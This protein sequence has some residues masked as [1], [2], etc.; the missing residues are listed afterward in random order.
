MKLD[1]RSKGKENEK[2]EN[3]DGEEV[4]RESLNDSEIRGIQWHRFG[5]GYDVVV[6]VEEKERERIE[7][8]YVRLRG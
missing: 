7:R 3:G 1:D 6:V 2:S 8:W 5:R 4:R